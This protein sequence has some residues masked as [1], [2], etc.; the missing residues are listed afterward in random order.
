MKALIMYT[1]LMEAITVAVIGMVG[2]IIVAFVEKGRRDNRNDHLATSEKLDLVGKSLGRSI[3]R[4]EKAVERTEEKIDQH[5]RDHA[6][7][8]FDDE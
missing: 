5:I 1:D 6:K 7:G 3:D 2:G 4:I 8:V